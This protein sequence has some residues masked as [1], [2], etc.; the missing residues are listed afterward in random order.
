M[1]APGGLVLKA[2]P[3]VIGLLLYWKCR[4]LAERFTKDLD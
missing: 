3:L 4:V 1:S 2:V